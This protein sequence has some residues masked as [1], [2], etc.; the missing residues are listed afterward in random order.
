MTTSPATRKVYSII[1]LAMFGSM[2]FI[3]AMILATR[4]VAA[5]ALD[6]CTWTNSGR[7]I[8]ATAPNKRKFTRRH[9]RGPVDASGSPAIIVVPTRAGNI[10][11]APSFAPKIVPFIN[12]LVDLTGK[13]PARIKCHA[14][15][16]HVAN[17]LHY[18]G[19]ACDFEQ[20]GW[21]CTPY[22]VMYAVHALAKKYGLRDGCEFAD[23]GHIDDG[24]HLPAKR[25]RGKCRSNPLI[26][27]A[28]LQR[29][30]LNLSA[31]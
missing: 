24:P 19:R 31:L 28:E 17:S 16:G 7:Y 18:R 29:K 4:P 15:S 25:I 26:T 12:A 23:W 10:A 6:A 1:A 2:I 5:R 9:R 8:C 22:K 30:R 21:G 20:C 13:K 14:T 27:Y 3:I 11:V